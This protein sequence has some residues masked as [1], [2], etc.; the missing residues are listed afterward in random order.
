MT[1]SLLL[2]LMLP[3]FNAFSCTQETLTI[4]HGPDFEVEAVSYKP[5]EV[6]SYIIIIPPTG[7][8][9]FIDRSYA[10]GLCQRGHHVYI[11]AHWTGL[12]EINMELEIHRRLYARA[13]R[14][15]GV[16]LELV[17]KEAKV[18]I[19]G[20]SVGGLHAAIAA[21]RYTQI[22]SSMI[23]LGGAHIP[24]II[25]NSDQKAMVDAWKERQKR[26]GFKN[27]TEYIEALSQVI[28]LEAFDRAMISPPK[29][30]GMVISTGDQTVPT[31]NQERLKSLWLPE[32]VI[33]KDSGHFWSILSTWLFEKNFI[34]DFFK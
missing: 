14:A 19:L 29:K 13:Y 24:S 25:A 22:T 3:L 4:N 26:Y 27:K 17:P 11:L 23:I 34:Y 9:N 12:D 2:G 28:E 31:A 32:H 20:T 18:G 6:K 33:Y 7:G 1:K 5:Q 30:F 15:I 16:V 10:K 8:T 21:S